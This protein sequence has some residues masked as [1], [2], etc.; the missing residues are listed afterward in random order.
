MCHALG[1]AVHECPL[2]R[3]VARRRRRRVH[4]HALTTETLETLETQMQ[5]VRRTGGSRRA[6]AEKRKEGRKEGAAL[7]VHGE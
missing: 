4:E 1:L 3:L 7:G 5:A 2:V 6:S